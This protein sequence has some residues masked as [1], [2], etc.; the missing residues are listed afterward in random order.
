MNFKRGQKVVKVIDVYGSKTA[1]VQTVEK[2][3]SGVVSLED[4]SLKFDAKTGHE[5][6][7]AFVQFFCFLVAFDGGEV[8]K[9]GLSK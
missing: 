5:I 6:D 9:W 1:T 7:P 2:V 4:S 3:K 8:E